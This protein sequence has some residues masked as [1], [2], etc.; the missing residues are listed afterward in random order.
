MKG[1]E[2]GNLGNIFTGHSI[3]TAGIQFKIS[4][5]EARGNDGVLTEE[6][7]GYNV[8]IKI[9]LAALGISR[10]TNGTKLG[11]EL[12]LDNAYDAFLGR[13][14][15]QKWWSNSDNSWANAGIWGTAKLGSAIKGS[16]VNPPITP[17]NEWVSFWSD[18]TYFEGQPVKAGDIIEAFDPQGV[19][20]GSFTVTATGRYGLMP[21]YCDDTT[22]TVDEG[23]RSGDVITFKING[24]A[25][26]TYGPA[27]PTWTAN[28]DVKKVNLIATNANTVTIPLKN[29]WN[30]VSWNVDTQ[31]DSANILL[32][33][34]V[35]KLTVAL[36][37]DNGGMTFDPTI[38]AEFNTLKIADHL[39]GYWLKMKDTTS[40]VVSGSPVAATT[41]INLNNGYNLVSYLPTAGDSVG[42]A[43]GSIIAKTKV[44][45]GFENG[46]LTYDPTIPSNFNSL[47]V[48]KPEFGYWI[49]TTSSDTLMY[50]PSSI[51]PMMAKVSGGKLAKAPQIAS[52]IPSREW[53]SMW[54]DNI[55]LHRTLLPIGTM[56][57]A[58]TST[59]LVCGVGEVW[60]AGKFGLISI[61]KDDAETRE[62]E[63]AK[64]GEEITIYIGD[65]R[66]PKS[67]QW[68]KFG[69]VVNFNELVTGIAE[70][71]PLPTEFALHQNYPNPFNP[72]TTIQY[73][74]PTRSIV[75]LVI[76]NILGQVVKELINTEQQAGYQSVVWNANVASGM[77][78]Y[79]IEATSLDNPNKRFVDTKKMLL[80]K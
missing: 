79:R 3:D 49:K 31:V 44:V 4:D 12:Q 11:L 80:L 39:H 10:P 48:M 26:R 20:C 40:L 61:Y 47:K 68:T 28:G 2:V 74:L 9:P 17:T 75:R 24:Y 1:H 53:I 50:P 71:S 72:A 70:L 15:M 7:S 16:S 27:Q 29:S 45:L 35:N 37:F 73:A 78:F 30:L 36:S 38:P 65:Y 64:Q 60:E 43:L 41:P 51:M 77:Y 18:S 13:Q 58:K 6:G 14:S 59:G 76:Y 52:V 21:V 32:G 23:A 57:T 63:G 66:V 54:G 8:E 56:I 5:H 62:V 25:A 19:H 69:D 46:G 34:I 55:M 33:S 22:T 42:H 67:I